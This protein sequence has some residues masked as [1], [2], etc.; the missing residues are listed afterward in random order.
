MA[1]EAASLAAERARADALQTTMGRVNELSNELATSLAE[2][3][4]LTGTPNAMPATDAA[5][6]DA[7]AV[8]E[9]AEA[10]AEEAEAVAEDAAEVA[11]GAE[12]IADD[13]PA[14]AESADDAANT[15]AEASAEG[16]QASGSE[17]G[18]GLGDEAGASAAE[19][20][21][22]HTLTASE[23]AVAATLPAVGASGAS[24]A[25]IPAAEAGPIPDE[26]AP[27]I[28]DESSDVPETSTAVLANHEAAPGGAI[29]P[30]ASAPE[31]E[32]SSQSPFMAW[33]EGVVERLRA[34]APSE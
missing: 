10:V 26:A 12:A 27:S 1:S 14:P 25:T 15:G 16:P 9:E 20:A 21:T 22:A 7:A 32:P 3:Q 30:V 11:E 29:P 24:D 19:D 31:P 23:D 28:L 18:N 34:L 17:I 6:E 5:D 13:A 33:W 4:A 2:L 8:A